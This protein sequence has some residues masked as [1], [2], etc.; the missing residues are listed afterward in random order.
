MSDFEIYSEV[1]CRLNDLYFSDREKYDGF[2]ILLGQMSPNIFAKSYSV[3][4]AW[5]SEFSKKLNMLNKI[6]LTVNDGLDIMYNMLSEY[7]HP[8]YEVKVV[9]ENFGS[10]YS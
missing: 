3:D 5:F 2:G 10:L 4:P 1:F 6:N 7:N 9:L 8:P